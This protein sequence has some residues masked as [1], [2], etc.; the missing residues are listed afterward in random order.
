MQQDFAISNVSYYEI[1]HIT[2][3]AACPVHHPSRALVCV[4]RHVSVTML[5]NTLQLRPSDCRI[6]MELVLC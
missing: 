4:L 2:C 1:L 3:T 5:C 6:Q